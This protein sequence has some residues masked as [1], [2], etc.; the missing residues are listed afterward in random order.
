MHAAPPELSQSRATHLYRRNPARYSWIV[1]RGWVVAAAVFAAAAAGCGPRAREYELRGVVVAVDAARQEITIQHEDIPRFMP[2]MTMPFKVR[3]AKLLQGRRPGDL[4]RATLVVEDSDAHLR[5]LERTG[6]APIPELSAAAP[7][8]RTVLV[9]GD[10]VADATFTDQD[11]RIR[12]LA[13]WR[14]QVL[15]VTFI[16]TRCPIPNFCPLMDRHF[17]TAAAA[18]RQDAGLR[19]RVRLLSV[20]FDPAHDTP[21]VLAAHAKQLQA[22]PALWTFLTGEPASVDR[23]AARFGVSVIREDASANEIVHSL[24]TAVIGAD[25]RL[26]AMLR[27][28]EWTPSEL[29]AELRNAVAGR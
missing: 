22:D 18:I 16:Y 2:G 5:A 26:A 27:G 15:A 12:R 6:S 8:P 23:F 21:A 1:A 3:D 14:G 10:A 19:D 25:G 13:D 9:P 24:G 20:S 28:N 29:V 4:V 7:A 11:G 17:Q